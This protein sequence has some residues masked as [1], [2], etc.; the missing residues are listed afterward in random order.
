MVELISLDDVYIALSSSKPTLYK[1]IVS[2]IL[3]SSMGA[4]TLSK[5]TLYDFLYA[6][7]EYFEDNEDK[8][9]CNLLKKDP[10]EIVP[11]WKLKSQGIITFSTPESTFY[12]FLYLK[13][14]RMDDF[15]NLNNPLFRRG[16]NNFLTANKISSC[17][18]EF[19]K[20]LGTDKNYFKSKN[21]INTFESIC[22]THFYFDEE[23]KNKLMDLFEGKISNKSKYFHEY[24]K[25]SNEIKKDYESLI[26]YLTAR[27]S[28]FEKFLKY[29][30]TYNNKKV[31][32]TDVILKYYQNNIEEKLHLSYDQ[33][34]LLC[35]L[36][37]DLAIDD[38]LLSNDFYLN[39]VFKKAIVKLSI[40]NHDFSYLE[41]ELEDIL[42]GIK[43]TQR[44]HIFKVLISQLNIDEYF[45]IN[46]DEVYRTCIDYLVDHNMYNSVITIS[47]M[48][49][50][51]EKI[52]FRLIDEE[53]E[54]TPI[55]SKSSEIDLLIK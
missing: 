29:Y 43:L 45:E 30:L 9:I 5:L 1:A 33:S 8:T 35:K 2:L 41:F 40:I 36:A 19:N 7:D 21:L 18:T 14:K 53:P 32:K 20:V 55:R 34:K 25:Y 3:S 46:L 37:Q 26:P 10:W 54:V 23:Y 11:C 4:S 27:E 38:S 51:A 15:D 49:N 42:P 31:N 28:N 12:L 48:P 17:V 13:E 24:L 16:D 22:N 6:C 44:A 47:N 52:L 50:I 39:K